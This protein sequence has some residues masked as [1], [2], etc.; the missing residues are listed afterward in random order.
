MRVLLIGDGLTLTT[1]FAQVIRHIACEGR[2]RG[3]ALA[4]IASL[5]TPPFC[6]SEPYASAGVTPY[7][8]AGAGDIVGHSVLDQA[9]RMEQ[10]DAVIIVTDPGMAHAWMRRLGQ[11]QP[12]VPTVMYAPI[13]GAPITAEYG[14]AFRAADRALTFTAWSAD[15]LAA[16]GAPAVPW[17]Y[18]GVAAAV[19]AYGATAR[20]RR[21]ELRAAFGWS[22]RYVIAYVA[23]NA[24]RKQQPTLIQALT[25]LTKLA[26]PVPDRDYHLYL[27]C[28]PYESHTLSGWDLSEVAEQW[29][30]ADRVEFAPSAPAVRGTP[31]T[32]VYDRIVA[33]DLYVSVA[34]SEG[35]GLPLAEA[36]ALGTPVLAPDD[37]GNQAEVVGEGGILYRVDHWTTWFNGAQLA[38]PS[39]GRVA[40]SIKQARRALTD[41]AARERLAEAATRRVASFSWGAMAEA[42]ADAAER[43]AA[44]AG[45]QYHA[46]ACEAEAVAARD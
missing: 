43:A 42:I 24:Q 5:D 27:H 45:P 11:Y 41:V 39:P 3:W 31:A 34:G 25:L 12:H 17:V 20:Q 21:A 15:H 16:S 19:V 35:F 36:M 22:D 8:P 2:R 44:S 10:P 18:H 46:G 14:E 28:Q 38:S 1:G 40:E 13:E 26:G 33:A 7:F 23:R 4:Q 32:A 29:G 9:L 30:V 6:R 37:A